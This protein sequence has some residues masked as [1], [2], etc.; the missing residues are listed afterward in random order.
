MEG[1]KVLRIPV[2]I[3]SAGKQS[4]EWLKLQKE[5]E[6]LSFKSNH[7]IVENADHLSLVMNKDDAQHTIAA[8]MRIIATIR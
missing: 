8:I 1:K 5:L 7:K 2:E 6:S 3:I 4:T